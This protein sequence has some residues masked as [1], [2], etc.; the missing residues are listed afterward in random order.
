MLSEEFF[1]HIVLYFFDNFYTMSFSF[2]TNVDSR[3]FH[4]YKNTTWENIK[5]G[6]E[7]SVRLE[8]NEILERFIHIVVL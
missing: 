6:Q 1:F 8:T 7:I 4:I 5:I 2:Q 3:G